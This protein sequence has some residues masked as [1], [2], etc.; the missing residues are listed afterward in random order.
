MQPTNSPLTFS[1]TDSLKNIP[2]EDWDNLFGKDLIESYGYQ[3]TLEE[4]GLQEF[5]FRYLL[6][7]R[8]YSLN[9]IIPFF[10]TEFPL[11]TLIDGCIHKIANKFKSISRL[12]LLF[13]GSI[14]TEELYF[15][16]SK[17]ENLGLLMDGALEKISRLCKEEKIAGVVLYNLS[18]RHKALAEYL[19]EKGFIEM[20]SLPGT[21]IEIKA[22]SI[23][24]Y[25]KTLSRNT[26]KDLKKKLR[27]SSEQA[28]LVTVIR[29]D[30]GD[31][32]DEVYK[33]YMNNFDESSVHFEVLT[34]EFFRRIFQNMPGRVKLFVTYDKDKIVAFNLC[35]IRGNFCID[36]FIGL[37]S[38]LALKY[39]LY[40]T[41]LYHNLD[42]CIKNGIRFYQ[43]G[44]T[45]YHPKMRFGAKLIPLF[46]YSKAF[47]PLLNYAVKTLAKFIQPKNLDSSY[48]LIENPEKK[49]FRQD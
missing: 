37:D 8:S 43:P 7:R 23:E 9:A 31:I 5:S 20:E 44:A 2:Q 48:K 39:H 35:L 21:I 47:N 49:I 38:E 19:K 30:I 18:G 6:A 29:E 28:Q 3:K 42:W 16:I 12:K 11:T 4:S 17:E 27:R 34:P 10:I 22:P 45:D 46:V 26:R 25:I 14:T 33:L 13:V 32:V 41:T 15:G 40:F 24:E 36:K 1:I